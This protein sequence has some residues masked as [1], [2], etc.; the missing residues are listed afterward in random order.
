M[1]NLINKLIDKEKILQLILI[2]ILFYFNT[3]FQYIPIILLKIDIKTMSNACQILLNLFSNLCILTILFAI[4]RKDLKEYF[5]K[6]IK[7]LYSNLDTAIKYYLLGLLGMIITNLFINVVLKGGGSNNEKIVQDMISNMPY[8][9]IIVAGIIAPIIEEIV[10]RKTYLDAFKNKY[11][12]FF[13]SSFIFGMMHVV[14]TD[15][16]TLIDVLYF[17]P[18]TCLG[19]SF[20]VMDYKE[21]NIFPS[22]CM[23]IFHNTLLIILSIIG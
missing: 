20:A 18:Y 15:I 5:K 17:I 2:F 7:N 9:M 3:I 23:H 22:I 11:L 4:Y 16:N 1:K 14:S 19:L 12:Y 21:E 6:F 10:F 8:L 13:L